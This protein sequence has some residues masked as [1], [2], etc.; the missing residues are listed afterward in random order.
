M[1]G[2]GE[3]FSLGAR[4]RSFAHAGAGLAHVLATQHNARIHALA[5]LAVLALGLLLGVSRL[6]WCLLVAAIAAVWAAEAHNTALESLADALKP[7]R[8][9]QVGRA[10]DAAAGAV[11]AASLGAAAIGLLVLGPRLWAWLLRLA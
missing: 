11:L 6:E 10:K 7:E 9:A 3:R 4:A 1:A 8:D 5:T 2:D